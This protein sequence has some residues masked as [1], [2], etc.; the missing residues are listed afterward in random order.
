M[1]PDSSA[2]ADVGKVIIMTVVP[3]ARRERS[4]K[5]SDKGP[6]IVAAL[7][8]GTTKTCCMIGEVVPGRRTQTGD[9]R[10]T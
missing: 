1:P 7:D 9:V 3:L 8:I 2:C 10:I 6:K 4:T 5:Q